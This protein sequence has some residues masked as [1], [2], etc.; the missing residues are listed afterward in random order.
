MR[1]SHVSGHLIS[2]GG[3]VKFSSLIITPKIKETWVAG[4]I[5]TKRM[6]ELC[7]KDLRIDENDGNDGDEN[8]NENG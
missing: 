5:L 3:F 1:P 4:Y 6:M 2:Y 7:G 8:V